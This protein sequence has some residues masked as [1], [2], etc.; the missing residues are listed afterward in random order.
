LQKGYP[1]TAEA[2]VTV[3]KGKV[4]VQNFIFTPEEEETEDD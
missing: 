3:E 2:E 1:L 4:R